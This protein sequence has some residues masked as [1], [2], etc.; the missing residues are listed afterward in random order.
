MNNNAQ[1]NINGANKALLVSIL[2]SA[3]ITLVPTIIELIGMSKG[4]A[5]NIPVYDYILEHPVAN[6]LVSQGIVIG[7]FIVFMIVNK[8]NYP[9]YI[10]LKKMKISNILLTMLLGLLMKPLLTLFNALSLCFSRNMISDTVFDISASLPYWGGLLLVCVLPGIVEESVYRGVLYESYREANPWKAVLLS[11]FLFGV[12]HGNL[13]QFSY[14][15]VLGIVFALIV[16]ATDSILATM[17]IHF[18][19]NFLSTSLMYLIPKLYDAG[20][21]LIRYYTEN[22]DADGIT[23]I[24]QL[25]GD[26]SVS[27]EQWL[28]NLLSSADTVRMTVGEVLLTYLPS[29]V[30]FTTLAFLVLRLIAKRTGTW[31]RFRVTY[32][33]ADEIIVEAEQPDPYVKEREVFYSGEGNT[34]LHI[35]TTPLMAAIAVGIVVIFFIET[36]NYLPV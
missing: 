19:T 24:T 22:G 31:D 12:M 34:N 18:G 10:R 14:A 15:F 1:K 20:N 17:L 4:I 23:R 11:A 32:L 13:N 30:I 25:L 7:P 35:M 27:Y 3:T 29:A 21:E 26:T 36:L 33:G 16:E 28:N 2:I 6:I 9:K 8:I 5:I